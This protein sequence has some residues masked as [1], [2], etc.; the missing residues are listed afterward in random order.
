MARFLEM[1]IVDILYI[2]LSV[3]CDTGLWRIYI[4]WA[5]VCYMAYR[6]M[7]NVHTMDVCVLHGIPGYINC[8]YSG[9]LC[10]AFD[11]GLWEMYIQWTFVCY[12]GY[13]VMGNV[14]IVDV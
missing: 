14:H 3:A 4:K 5:F 13:R 10:V 8:T 7:G 9:R 2:H 11:T 12:M 6:V 1:Y